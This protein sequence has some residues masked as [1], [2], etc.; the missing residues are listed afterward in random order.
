MRLVHLPIDLDSPKLEPGNQTQNNTEFYLVFFVCFG[1]QYLHSDFVSV[2]CSI[3]VGFY[4][5]LL[6]IYP[7]HTNGGCGRRQSEVHIINWSMVTCKAAPVTGTTLKTTG[8]V[9]ADPRHAVNA[10]GT[11]L[12][13][14]INSGL[15]RWRMAI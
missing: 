11:Q 2:Q 3:T 7:L 4:P 15:T 14:P 13:D 12:R 6:S 5:I 10:I 8:P 9:P 1:V